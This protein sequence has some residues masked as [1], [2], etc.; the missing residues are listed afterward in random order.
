MAA[1]I[2]K[3]NEHKDLKYEKR[4]RNI[5]NLKQTAQFQLNH[6]HE[7]WTYNC[8]VSVW[9]QIKI[10]IDSILR[11]LKKKFVRLENS[12]LVEY[13]NYGMK[14]EWE[15]FCHVLSIKENKDL[16]KFHRFTEQNDK[17]WIVLPFSCNFLFRHIISFKNFRK[18]IYNFIGVLQI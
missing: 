14:L 10:C 12:K 11:I 13:L 16:L 7:H 2:N 18:H 5:W 4:W 6:L 15:R 9:N 17:L 3:L 8:F 1:K